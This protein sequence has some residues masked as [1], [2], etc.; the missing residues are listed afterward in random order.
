MRRAA[1]ATLT[2][3]F[4]ALA[5]CTS[6]PKPL[7]DADRAMAHTTDSA[8]TMA[9]AAGNVDGMMAGYASDAMVMP[10][11]M[12]MAHGA[13]QI[14]QLWKGMSAGKVSLQL[15]Q[16]TADGAGDFMYT[17]GKYHY[18]ALPAE[19]GAF[20]DGKYLE[21]FR[22]GTDGKW[23]LA[24]ESWSPNAPPAPMAPAAPVKPAAHRA[25]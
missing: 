22:R 5:G 20:E 7:T 14:R 9:A 3:A 6:A 1:T 25:R 21:V 16:E 11:S 17:T 2:L 18:Q 12:P 15:T 13:D 10:P 8:F 23:M 4:A 24:A 19:T